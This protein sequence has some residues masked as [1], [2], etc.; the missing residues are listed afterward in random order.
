MTVTIRAIALAAMAVGASAQV[1]SICS[2]NS[3]KELGD[4]MPIC[5]G[6]GG[7]DLQEDGSTFKR[8][9]FLVGLDEFSRIEVTDSWAAR[10]GDALVRTFGN[11]VGIHVEAGGLSSFTKLYRSTVNDANVTF[12]YFTIIVAMDDGLVES[13][14]W[15]DGCHFCASSSCTDATF[16]LDGTPQTTDVNR[17]CFLTDAACLQGS[18]V[19]EACLL[20]VYVVFSGTDSNGISMESSNLR[21]SRFRQGN[22]DDFRESTEST[23]VSAAN[24]ASDTADSASDTANDV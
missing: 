17:D 2:T 9:G 18:T 13:L 24:T 7:M 10:P 12:P 21:F 1:A 4:D 14:T 8:A 5:V 20:T 15:D 23:Y 22:L 16:K 11:D 6:I 19:S 3:R